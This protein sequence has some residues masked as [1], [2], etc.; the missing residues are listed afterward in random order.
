MAFQ[1]AE[2]LLVEGRQGV[3]RIHYDDD[4]DQRGAAAQIAAD[5]LAPLGAQRLGNAREA[6]AGQVDEVREL[7]QPVEVD[8][9]RTARGL[10]RA[11]ETASPEERIDGARLAD[12]RAAR[13]GDLGQ[14]G[15]RQ[16]A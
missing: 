1:P 15:R 2:Q 4:A 11:G 9:L 6:I 16:V 14:L 10:A 7:A 8:G 3:P 12:V 13:E 5:E